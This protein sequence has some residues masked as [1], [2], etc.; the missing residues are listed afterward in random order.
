[1]SNETV[2]DVA[3]GS[4]AGRIPPEGVRVRGRKDH[5]VAMRPVVRAW[6]GLLAAVGIAVTMGACGNSSNDAGSTGASAQTVDTTPVSRGGTLRLARSIEPAT[7]NP[8]YNLEGNGS[9]QTMAAIYDTLVEFTPGSL[10]AKPGLATSWDVSADKKTFTFHLRDAKF[11][12][13]SPVTSA[14]VKYSLARLITPKNPYYAMFGLMK[15]IETPDPSTIVV[16]LK[17]PTIGFPTY[18]GFPGASIV[19]KAAIGRLGDAAFSRH[20]VGSGPFK[21]KRWVK[22]QVVELVRNPYYWRRGQPYL[23]GVKLLY[24]PND[25]TRTLDLL[26]GNADAVD[27]VPFSQVDQVNN[28]GDS[29]VLI[30]DS[31]GM[32]MVLLNEK[33]KPLDETEARQALNYATPLEQIRQTVFGGRVEVMNAVF[34]KMKYWSADVKPYEYDLDKAKELL[35]SSSQPHGF[36]LTLNIISGDDTSK[37]VGQILQ[38]SWGK[39]GVDVSLRQLDLGT[40]YTRIL[41]S[42]YEAV[43]PIPDGATSD[44]PNPDE[45]ANLLFNSNDT[46]GHNNFTW[47]ANKAIARLSMQ[48]IH[49]TDAAEQERLFAKLQQASLD[50]PLTVPLVFMPYRS[51]ARSNVHGFQYVPTGWW[52]LEQVSLER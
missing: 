45:W 18:V 1:M 23:D 3:S 33:V 16:T 7:L 35:A 51:A 26:S 42:Q 10:D 11:S 24:V 46:I 44:I 39:I 32:Y 52:R 49:T 14:D 13:G 21:L 38:D 48:A 19:S 5:R 36:D 34:P 6:L 17:Q 29:K 28:S 22:G 41:G 4:R 9:L 20:P 50:D 37:Q 30:Q 25:N 40:F 47:Y 31:V 2:V 8:F 15:R 43:L 27:A 12:D